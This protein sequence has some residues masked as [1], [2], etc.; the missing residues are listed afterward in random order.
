MSSFHYRAARPDGTIIETDTEGETPRAVRAQLE[1]QGLLVLDLSGSGTRPSRSLTSRQRPLALR[2]FL[3]FN[4]EFLALVKAGLP[5]LRCF[6]LLTDRLAPGGFQQALQSVRERIR[7]GSS[8]SEAMAMHP[9]YFPELYQA[10]LRAG[11]QAGNLP[12][13]LKRYIDYLKMLIGVREKVVKATIYPIFLLGFGI[14]VTIG[15]LFF[16][17]PSF[18][19]VYQESRVELPWATQLLLDVTNSASQ[20]II[21]LL[22]VLGVAGVWVHWWKKTPQGQWRIHW[23]LLN[24]P[25]VGPLF[26]KNQV[27]RLVRTLS[28]ILGGGIPLLSALQVT[29]HSMPNKVF[30]RALNSV[31]THVREGTSLSAALKKEKFLPSLT[32]EMIE[33]GE[34]TGALEAM[35]FEVAE[36]HEGELD[37]QLSRMMTWIEPIFIILIGV[38]LGGVVIALYLP[39][40][41]MAGAV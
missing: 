22:L 20:W 21:G 24:A 19:E 4:Q 39:I 34:T 29:A 27:I 15:L 38:I 36:F 26:L 12:E 13:V 33:V 40:F 32:L 41:Q 6:D 9:I 3:V 8:I 37:F 5:M 23:L 7:G 16:V 28:T 17:L 11:E 25:I 14:L 18:A 31:I 2:D 10:S 30:A 35:L 1:A